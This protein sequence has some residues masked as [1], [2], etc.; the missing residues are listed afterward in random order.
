MRTLYAGAGMALATGLLLGAAM[1]PDLGEGDGRPAGP[2]IF[3]G[4]SGARSTGPFDDGLAFASYTQE[5]PEYV[6]GTDW[7]KLVEAP[8]PEQIE[9]AVYEESYYDSPLDDAA[10]EPPAE[11]WSPGPAIHQA[12]TGAA[13]PSLDG[14]AAYEDVSRAEKTLVVAQ[15]SAIDHDEAP[16]EATGDTTLAR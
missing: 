6:L 5:I 15:P 7:R 3:T 13:Y 16:P 11:P 4:W 10:A 14:G 1:K 8:A 9:P 2:Q 12:E